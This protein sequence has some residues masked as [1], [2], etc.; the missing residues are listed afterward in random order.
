M[1]NP[2]ARKPEI[3]TDEP[4]EIN[5][6]DIVHL[7][8]PN[9][10]FSIALEYTINNADMEMDMRI[11]RGAKAM[12]KGDRPD[13]GALYLHWGYGRANWRSI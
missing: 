13:T 7:E 1:V 2:G 8:E 3:F 6:L 9:T 5:G 11:E 4:S 12:D 10:A